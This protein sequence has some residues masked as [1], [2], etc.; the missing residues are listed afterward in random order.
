MPVA[1]TLA[2]VKSL[3]DGQNIPGP[4]GGRMDAFINAP[5][6]KEDSR[7]P[8]AYIWLT[9]GGIRRKSGPRSAPPA[10]RTQYTAQ[11]PAGWKIYTHNVSIWV[12][13]FDENTDAGA[14]SAFPTVLDWTMMMLETCKMP[15]D[16]T[17]PSTGSAL[18]TLI[19]LGQNMD[20]EYIPARSVLSQRYHRQDALITAPTEEWIQR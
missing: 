3:L 7:N 4:A 14:D 6:P 10:N 2:F 12:T 17:D 8:A 9:R 11:S 15:Q 13:W 19:N 1:T 20:Y 18:S 16:I 5:D